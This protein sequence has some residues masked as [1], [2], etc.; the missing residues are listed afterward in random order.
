[1]YEDHRAPPRGLGG[2]FYEVRSK[3]ER[4]YEIPDRVRMVFRLVE[5]ESEGHGMESDG[6]VVKIKA[7]KLYVVSSFSAVH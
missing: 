2:V 7:G 5:V 3:A 4:V 6:V 1:L